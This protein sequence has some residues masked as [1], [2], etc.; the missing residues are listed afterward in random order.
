MRF[1]IITISVAFAVA[2]CSRPP[3]PKTGEPAKQQQQLEKPSGK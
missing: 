3:T 2:G 1:L